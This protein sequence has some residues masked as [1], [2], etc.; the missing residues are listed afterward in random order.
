MTRRVGDVV[1]VEVEEDELYDGVEEVQ[2]G[3]L[4]WAK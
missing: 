1:I 3:R 2:V 4:Q